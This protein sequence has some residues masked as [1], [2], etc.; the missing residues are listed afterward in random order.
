MVLDQIGNLQDFVG[1]AIARFHQRTRGLDR[2]VFPLPA[3]PQS[4]LLPD[5]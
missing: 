2:E 3:D 1:K 5:V 4:R